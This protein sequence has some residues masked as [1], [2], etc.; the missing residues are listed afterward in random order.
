ML[1]NIFRSEGK[2]RE[3]HFYF[4]LF[5]FHYCPEDPCRWAQGLKQWCKNTTSHL[6]NLFFLRA[7]YFLS[8]VANRNCLKC[9]ESTYLSIWESKGIHLIGVVKGVVAFFIS[10]NWDQ[11]KRP[12][13]IKITSILSTLKAAYVFRYKKILRS[14]HSSFKFFNWWCR[15]MTYS[16]QIYCNY[17]AVQCDQKWARPRI[18]ILSLLF[19][20][21][22]AVYCLYILFSSTSLHVLIRATF[23][24]VFAA[25]SRG[26]MAN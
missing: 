6:L 3:E 12:K 26:K 15:K 17:C 4:L 14:T 1:L 13:I 16:S 20:Y 10:G 2:V 19:I 5:G 8:V 9:L 7:S 25:N 21:F 23:L 18:V 24:S 11:T 22:S